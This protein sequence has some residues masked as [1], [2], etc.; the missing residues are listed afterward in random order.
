M[1][2]AYISFQQILTMVILMIIGYICAKVGMIDDETNKKLS[3]LLL[4]LVN[5]LLILLSYQRAFEVELLNGLKWSVILSVISF[6]V[7]I[8]VSQ[9]VYKDKEGKDYAIEKF[10]TIYSNA[11]FLG[12]PL[13]NGVFGAEGVFY[14]TGYLTVFFL[15]FWSH[16]LIIMSGKRDF[17]AVKRAFLSPPMIAIFLGF[18]LFILRIEI[19]EVIHTPLAL[20]GNVNTPLA[21][22]VA[23]VSMTS[24]S[25]GSILKNKKIYGVCAMRLLAVPALTMLLFGFMPVPDMVRGTIV[26]VAACPIAANII[27]LA[28][29]YNK[30]HVYSAQ[31]FTASTIMSLVT[32]PFLLLW[33]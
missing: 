29:R 27:M 11:G 25:I 33:L 7:A 2:L 17:T 26:M 19:P 18:A 22:I 21:M 10:G 32:I 8:V 13:V 12:I 30:N 28:Y 1:E 16:G 3:N 4:M 5:P 31:V 6:V 15:F 23:G 9:I 20:L 24:A 14:L